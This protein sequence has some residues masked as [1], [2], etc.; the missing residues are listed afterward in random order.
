MCVHPRRPGAT[1]PSLGQPVPTRI[2]I[3]FYPA[4]ML[5]TTPF[6]T[7]ILRLSDEFSRSAVQ[8]WAPKKVFVT[9]QTIITT[10]P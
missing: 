2:A 8:W 3:P 7:S 5:V 1:T 9:R 4:T 10:T 6:I